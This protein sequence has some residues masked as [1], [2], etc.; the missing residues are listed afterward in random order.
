MERNES[1]QT[2]MLFSIGPVQEFIAQARRTRD[3]WFGS[4]LLSE[5]SKEAAME[6]I[7]RG[8]ELIFPYVTR[9]MLEDKAKL[10]GLKVANKILGLIDAPGHEGAKQTA[11]HVRQAVE[12]KWMQYADDVKQWMERN[13]MERSVNP[14]IWKRQVNDVLEFHAVWSRLDAKERYADVLQQTERL[15]EARKTLKDFKQNNP[16]QR[17]GE[18]KSSLDGARESVLLEEPQHRQ[19]YLCLGIND[20]ETLDAISLVK[21]LSL[22]IEKQ[23]HTFP[24]VCDVA[25]HPFKAAL[26][27]DP[28]LQ[29]TADEYMRNIRSQYG[30]V[31]KF[32]DVQAG[33]PD[34]RLFYA[35]RRL[36]EFVEE[37]AEG[38][39]AEERKRIVAHIEECLQAVYKKAMPSP[40]YA[41]MLCDGDRMGESLRRLTT[42]EDH[43]RFS[44]HLTQFASEAEQIVKRHHGQLVYSGGDDVMAY[45]PITSCLDVS[46]E[47]YDTFTGVMREAV[48][49]SIS[50]VVQPTLSIGIAIAHMLEPLE[51]V[52]KLAA[53]AEKLAKRRRNELAIRFQKRG[54]GD[55]MNISLSFDHNPN[56]VHTMKRLQQCYREG[57]FSAQFAYELRALY[58]EYDSMWRRCPERFADPAQLHKLMV[59]EVER[60]VWKKK[61]EHAASDKLEEKY[62]PLLREFLE[63]VAADVLK[64]TRLLAE[65]HILAITFVKEGDIRHERIENSS[66]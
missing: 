32:N 49:E 60:L 10:G 16:G 13:G 40:Y 44:L 47:L 55:A 22:K 65:Q 56:P 17:F 12:N 2:L 7:E 28:Q 50:D 34:S 19:R 66:A 5:L 23:G 8:G 26:A 14:A 57:L 45:M 4:H 27:A 33:E 29:R 31:L 62:M 35:G 42:Y 15:M 24:S 1:M 20:Q 38:V 37:A 25:F 43:Q 59:G 52:R 54:G 58:R 53:E 9:E 41:F 63:G 48:P 64:R 46:D 21:R 6:W 30:G 18:K 61:P 36:E 51:E 3:L 11:L 39:S